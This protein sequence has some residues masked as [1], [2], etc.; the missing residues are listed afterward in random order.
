MKGVQLG[1]VEPKKLNS[2]EVSAELK[3]VEGRVCEVI[4]KAEW[5]RRMDEEKSVG[6]KL[7][8]EG[9]GVIL[10]PALALLD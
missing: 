9:G 10:T 8:T 4:S 1:I 6:M 7:L 3:T 5:I 2:G